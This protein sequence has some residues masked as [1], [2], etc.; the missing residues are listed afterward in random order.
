MASS[1]VDPASDVADEIAD[2]LDLVGIVLRE[3]QTGESVFDHDHQFKMIQPVGSEIINEVRVVRNTFDVR[4]QM[5]GNKGPDLR[6]VKA[7]VRS[8]YPSNR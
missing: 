4:V 6:D 3:L 8:W 5:L 1:S 2:H 7:S